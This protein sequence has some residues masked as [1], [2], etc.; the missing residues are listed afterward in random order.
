MR[1]AWCQRRTL[2]RFLILGP[3]LSLC[4]LLCRLSDYWQNSHGI[5][6]EPCPCAAYRCSEEQIGGLSDSVPFGTKG[7]HQSQKLQRHS[8]M[9]GSRQKA[10]ICHR[11][12]GFGIESRRQEGRSTIVCVVGCLIADGLRPV[13]ERSC[14]CCFVHQGTLLFNISPCCFQIEY[15][16]RL[17]GFGSNANI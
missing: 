15:L 13:R 14:W 1:Y 5:Q 11:I 17:K 3:A 2:S 4:R 16:P 6:R 7:C 8:H 9:P 12:D 10:L